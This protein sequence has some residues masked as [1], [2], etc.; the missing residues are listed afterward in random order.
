ME[1]SGRKKIFYTVLNQ[2][3]LYIAKTAF[4]DSSLIQREHVNASNVIQYMDIT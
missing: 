4:D 1:I 3:W 2:T